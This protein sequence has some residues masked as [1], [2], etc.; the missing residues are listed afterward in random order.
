MWLARG[1]PCT[2]DTD[3]NNR[4][5]VSFA[6]K[7]YFIEG[8]YFSSK[9]LCFVQET[10]TVD[11]TCSDNGGD[12]ETLRRGV[13]A[14]PPYKLSRS[15]QPN[16]GTCPPVEAGAEGWPYGEYAWLEEGVAGMTA[17]QACPDGQIGLATWDCGLSGDW[18]GFPS[19][20]SCRTIDFETPL[21][22]LDDDGSVPS[23][24]LGSL[25]EDVVQEG[26]LAPGDVLGVI[27]VVEK[28]ITVRRKARS[29]QKLLI[30]FMVRGSL[31]TVPECDI[32]CNL[33]IMFLFTTLTGPERPSD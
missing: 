30:F 26:D 14:L 33:S 15:L 1:S 28:A 3:V 32:V 6:D 7:N 11:A 2:D 27:A 31:T 25:H 12:C 22:E 9:D 10:Y 19:F 17:V 13:C 18:I 23:E 20:S 21:D 16:Y 5:P 29:H 8:S 24:V 4:C